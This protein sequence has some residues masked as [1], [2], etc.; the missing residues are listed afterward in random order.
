MKIRYLAILLLT[1]LGLY[2]QI[3]YDKFPEVTS[4]YLV[5]DVHIQKSPTDSFG[6]GDILIKDGYISQV[7]RSIEAPFDAYVVEGDSAYVYPAFIDALSHTGIAKKEEG[8]KPKVKFRG[9]PPNSVVGISPEQKASQLVD[10]SHESVK[11]MRESGFGLSHVVPRGKMLPG[12]GSLM[13]LS[14]ASNE[15]MLLADNSSMF[16]QL[17][18]T[19]GFYPSTVIGVMA[20]WKELYGQANFLDKHLVASKAKIGTTKRAKADKSLQALIPVTKSQQ[21]VY[22]KA[23]KA[24]DI[25]KAIS[26]QQ[27]LGYKLVLAE[28]KQSGPALQK[29]KKHNIPVLISAKL[30]KEVKEDK[31]KEGKGKKAEGKEK[32]EVDKKVK[33]K[34]KAIAKKKADKEDSPEVKALKARKKKS[35]EAYVGQAA[36]LEKE[37]IP[38]GISFLDSK[39]GD[40]KKALN[41]MIKAG[42]SKS[43]ALAAVT[44]HPAKILGVEKQ[45]GTIA[46]G[47]MANLFISTEPYFSA[48]ASIKF[49]FVEGKMTEL[50]IKPK[51]KKGGEG[52]EDF[53]KMLV[54]KWEYSVETPMGNYGG[55]VDIS[56]TDD[57]AVN[58]FSSEEPDEPM[59]GRDIEVG[60]KSLT[61]TMTLDMGST[62][63]DA[64][65][66]VDFDGESFSGT[67]EI[68]GMGSMPITGSKLPE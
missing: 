68:P 11:K 27:E 16:F 15:E 50:E 30:P 24:K 43:G 47:K 25:H 59:V 45:V 44:T 17:A 19:R 28:V 32:P 34:K 40:L 42:L 31:A 56:G 54:G 20:K 21:T 18:S 37:G 67:V 4:T 60:D 65:T 26:L 29:I 49:V 23:E 46:N 33:P 12:Q 62:S 39:P 9:H 41:R 53:K 3:D 38:F 51:K 64:T 1:Q 57:L 14:G 2:A 66:S 13:L 10:A 7:A 63:M 55:V 52:S 58:V 8:E 48:D 6:L 36:S 22:M 5:N 35:Y 61:Y